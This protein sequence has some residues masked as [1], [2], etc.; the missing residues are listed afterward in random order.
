MRLAVVGAAGRMGR[1]IIAAAALDGDV[2]IGAAVVGA[3]E[4]G[5]EL[6]A[7]AIVPVNAAGPAVADADVVVDFSSPTGFDQALALAVA[8]G[9]PLVSGTTGLAASQL[10]A[11]DEAATQ[12]PVLWAANFSAGVNVLEHLVELASRA[13]G[14]FDVEVM[15]A[16]HRRKVDAPSGTALVLGEAAARGRD[17]KLADI[18][19]WARSG[20]TG[21]RTNEE[22]GF[23]VVRGGSIVG[24]HTVMLCGDGELIELTHRAQDR[25]IFARGAVR[26]AKWL[27]DRP[28]SRY[29]MKDVLFGAPS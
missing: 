19:T 8:A 18:A 4:L 2:S 26:A 6:D 1:A 22:I 13:L 20:V 21:P 14:G 16:H 7:L 10:A 15:E 9:R 3:H 5:V 11:L 24:E 25:A 27:A 23:Q 28:P 17:R 12:I 29:T